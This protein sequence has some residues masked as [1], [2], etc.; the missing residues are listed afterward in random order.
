LCKCTTNTCILLFHPPT[1]SRTFAQATK[2]AT[3]QAKE[4]KIEKRNKRKGL[5]GLRYEQLYDAAM[6]TGIEAPA[7]KPSATVF[8]QL[9]KKLEAAG[10]TY[11]VL[12]DKVLYSID[13]VDDVRWY[14]IC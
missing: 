2:K 3:E 13:T 4:D 14:N 11:E 5:G 1:P 9:I 10:I 12:K 6:S 8:A 7:T